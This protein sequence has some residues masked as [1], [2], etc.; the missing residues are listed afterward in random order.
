VEEG[1]LK[2]RVTVPPEEGKANRA[3]IELLAKA[4]K[5]PKSSIRIKRGTTGRMKTLEIEGI[6]LAKLQEKLGIPVEEKS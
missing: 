5:V 6:S 4:L 3:V 2:I 1:R